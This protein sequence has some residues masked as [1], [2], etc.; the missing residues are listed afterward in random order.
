[1]HFQKGLLELFTIAALFPS[2][3]FKYLQT[4]SMV[5]FAFL[6]TTLHPW[7][8]V[9]LW[10]TGAHSY[11]QLIGYFQLMNV[12]CAAEAYIISY[13]LSDNILIFASFL[14]L[15]KVIWSLQ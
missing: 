2:L 4:H 9:I 6:I 10:S 15:L 12:Q 7:F 3:Y 8:T 1:M 14:L 5:M 13:I 11:F